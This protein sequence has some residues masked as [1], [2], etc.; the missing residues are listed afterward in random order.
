[1]N[2][3]VEIPY[4]RLATLTFPPICPFTL[5]TNPKGEWEVEGLTKSDPAL[6]LPGL[7]L[8]V[9]RGRKMIFRVPASRRF[10]RRQHLATLLIAVLLVSS[11]LALAA[12]EVLK[13]WWFGVIFW[14]L[15]AGAFAACNWKYWSKC[16][17]WI[18]YVGAEFVEVVFK[19]KAYVEQFCSLNGLTFRRKF[20]NFRWG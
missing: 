1:M 17:V 16:R 11:C 19:R 10:A 15:L 20:F 6:S 18:D 4:A 12:G 2:Y 7:P 3:Y 5:E 8:M 14:V 13:L 9:V